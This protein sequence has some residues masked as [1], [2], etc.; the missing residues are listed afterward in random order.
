MERQAY[1]REACG[2]IG[3]ETGLPLSL[4]LA[5]NKLV[6]RVGATEAG[7]GGARLVE[8]GAEI[9]FVGELRR[10]LEDVYLQLVQKERDG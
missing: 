8:A 3:R 10:T 6:S 7:P 9:Q 1:L 4:G 2:K 5:V